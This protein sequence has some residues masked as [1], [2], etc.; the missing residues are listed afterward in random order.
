MGGEHRPLGSLH[1]DMIVP[2]A[3]RI[4]RR[5]DST[6]AIAPLTIRK[7]VSAI[8]EAHIIIFAVRIGMPQVDQRSL[9][10]SAGAGHYLTTEINKLPLGIMLNEIGAL[11]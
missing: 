10:G 3:T 8:P 11:R 9:N 6:E 2:G 7:E 1:F 4:E 5:Q